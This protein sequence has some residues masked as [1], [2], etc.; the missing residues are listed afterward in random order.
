M[1]AAAIIVLVI[2]I[3]VNHSI[4]VGMHIIINDD[5][6]VGI[7]NDLQVAIITAATSSS[8]VTAAGAVAATYPAAAAAA[9]STVTIG[10]TCSTTSSTI[11][12]T[13]TS[14][15]TTSK[16]TMPHPH[17]RSVGEIIES[18]TTIAASLY[19]WIRIAYEARERIDL[20]VGA[21][22]EAIATLESAFGD[23]YLA[24]LLPQ[25]EDHSKRIVTARDDRP[26]AYWLSGPGLDAAVVQLVETAVVLRAFLGDPCLAKKIDRI[27]NDTFWPTFYELAMAFRVKRSLEG[28]GLL[29]LL[30][31]I[32]ENN[33]DF[34]VTI[35][36]GR[37][38]CEC[39]RVIR[40][41]VSEEGIRITQD[42]F[43]YVADAGYSALLPPNIVEC[44]HP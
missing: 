6:D 23:P 24:S 11:I 37:L 3:C 17:A 25:D 40:T 39:S 26:L 32:E 8:A 10:T 38:L 20:P 27:K 14:S 44:C 12:M 28:R 36:G 9:I 16:F 33:G 34:I 21:I 43:D 1:T 2:M 41:P 7:D 29:E 42:I 18:M 19:G 15:S 31:E 35:D 4:G 30:Q 13:P 22:E 5:V